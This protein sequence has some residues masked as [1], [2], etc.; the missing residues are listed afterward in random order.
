MN[1]DK[2]VK[3]IKNNKETIL[4][5]LISIIALII[6]TLALSFIKALI[7]VGIIDILLFLPKILKLFNIKINF[8]KKNN[9]KSINEGENM[10]KKKTISNDKT[11]KIKQ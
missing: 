4:I 5:I 11:K 10:N 3:L 7:I 8:S 1:K 9:K 6:G 2:F